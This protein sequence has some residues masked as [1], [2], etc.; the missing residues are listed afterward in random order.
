MAMC[1]R[2][3][4][5]FG[6]HQGN[7]C[8]DWS[9]G[10]PKKDCGHANMLHQAEGTCLGCQLRYVIDVYLAAGGA[11]ARAFVPVLDAMKTSITAFDALKIP[12]GCAGCDLPGGQHRF[13]CS[14]H[15]YTQ[16]RRDVWIADKPDGGL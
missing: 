14:V 10:E 16:G 1:K 11:L 15:G 3:L 5:Q 7:A 13:S 12:E 8:A 9:D 4:D 2:A 6:D